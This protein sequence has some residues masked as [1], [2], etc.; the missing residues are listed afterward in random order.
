MGSQRIGHDLANQ[1]QQQAGMASLLI[2]GKYKLS[3]IHKMV[4]A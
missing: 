2:T 3:K 1:E 4:I